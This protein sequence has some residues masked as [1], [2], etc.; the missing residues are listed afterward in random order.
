MP[1]LETVTLPPLVLEP[2]EPEPD[3][4]GGTED[5]PW[6]YKAD[7][8]PRKRP[9]R[10]PGGSGGSSST[11]KSGNDPQ[12]EK[13]IA[14]ELVDLSAPLAIISPLAVLHV[15]E[16]AD[17]TAHALGVVAKKHPTV[18]L[19]IESYFDSIAYK[20]LAFF[21]IGIP[22]AIMIDMGMMRPDALAGRPFQMQD[23]WEE[24]YGEDG[25]ERME[26]NLTPQRGLAADINGYDRP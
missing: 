21:V 14:A 22:I 2:A 4:E 13:R 6:G 12:F 17:R 8:T 25:V 15:A 26:E 11:R 20:D 23:K 3:S 9:G 1:D 24:L 10:P 16:R 7:G 5:A 19:A 18:K